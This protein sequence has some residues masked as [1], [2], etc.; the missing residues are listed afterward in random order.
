MESRK[1]GTAFSSAIGCAIVIF[2]STGVAGM[3][4]LFIPNYM[5]EYGYTK[6][7]MS[8]VATVATASGFLF[9]LIGAKL[10]SAM[11]PK[12]ALLAGSASSA[13][14]LCLLGSV[15]NLVL[16]GLASLFQGAVLGLGAHAS[17]A[18]VISGWYGKRMA[19][20]I[21]L[22]FGFSS[23]GATV[24]SFLA[25]Q[26]LKSMDYHAILLIFGVGSA[27]IGIAANLLLIRTPATQSTE[28]QH[29]ETAAAD[30][31]AFHDAVRSPAFIVFFIA[32]MGSATLYA[33]FMTFATAFWQSCGLSAA[34]SATNISLLSF[35]G[36]FVGMGAGAVIEKFG[37]K[38]LMFLTFGGFILGMVLACLFPSNPTPWFAAMGVLFVAFI[39]PVS[40]MPSLVLPELF[41]R[42]DYNKI[43][44]IGMAGYYLGA[45]C[46]SVLV[47]WIAEVSGSYTNSYICLVIIALVSVLLFLAALK[48]SPYR[49]QQPAQKTL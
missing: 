30:G 20:V 43:N 48:L 19:S 29:A 8:Y 35:F 2:L 38:I 24:M 45:A 9:S 40:S 16:L 17:C 26:M 7:Q 39:R 4:S 1:G 46:S 21:G 49:K 23:F 13:A 18:G 32:M 34:Q 25:G 10:I 28:G 31:I 44:S 22:V 3:F 47:A 36:A 42:R 11:G 12:R 37:A 15:D 27:I 33:G 14:F 5:A 41:G 6:M